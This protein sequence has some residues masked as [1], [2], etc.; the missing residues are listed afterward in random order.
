MVDAKRQVSLEAIKN[1][2]DT[3]VI[4]ISFKAGSTGESLPPL[5]TLSLHHLMMTRSSLSRLGLNLTC[6][7][8]ARSDLL[9]FFR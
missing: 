7:T 4:L 9:R 8:S 5:H 2:A 3:K 1:D 6:G